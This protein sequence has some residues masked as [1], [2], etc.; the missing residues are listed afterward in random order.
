V[1]EPDEE[2]LDQVLRDWASQ[3]RPAPD[4][5]ETL[6]KRILDAAEGPDDRPVPAAPTRGA[7]TGRLA[8]FAAGAAAAVVAAAVVLHLWSPNKPDES[9]HR[10]VATTEP[11]EPIPAEARFDAAG[12]ARRARLFGEMQRVFDDNL[13]WVAESNGDVLLGVEPEARPSPDDGKPIVVRLLVMTRKPGQTAWTRGQSIDL[14]VRDQELVEVA[15]PKSGNESLAVW[16]FRL[17]DGTI[18]VDTS[19]GIRTADAQPAAYSG[20]Q[21]PKVPRQILQL[22]SDGAEYRVFET[23]AVLPEEV[24]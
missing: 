17:P 8:W 9:D 2:R 7:W 20:V 11:T 12:L 5:L 10:S 19:L 22:K 13:A 1:N 3:Q 16:A 23:V 4:R 18:A 21:R 24:G 6:G 15:P 14:I